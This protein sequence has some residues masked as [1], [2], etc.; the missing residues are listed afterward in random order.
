MI[1][2]V[3]RRVRRVAAV[4]RYEPRIAEYRDIDGYLTPYEAVTL[5]ALAASLREP[6]TVVEIGS[7]K[8]KS[9][10][11]LARGLRAGSVVAIDPFD[12][13]GEPG[14]HELYESSRGTGPLRRQFV[15]RMTAL[16]VIDKIVVRQGFSSEFVGRDE[17][18]GL[19]FIDGDHS[20]EGCDFDYTN[21]APALVGGGLVAFHDFDASRPEL[22]PT[23]VVSNRVAPSGEFEFV[24]LYDSLWVGRR[25]ARA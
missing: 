24:G 5:Y 3:M 1:E 17:R 16:G 9:T 6:S 14:S 19:L 10:Y 12:A 15:E 22:G 18:V 11:C 7:W 20:R 13:S 2:R 25:R 4:R 8:G 23:W 21:Y